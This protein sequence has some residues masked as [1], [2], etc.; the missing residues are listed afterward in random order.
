MPKV[1]D[2]KSVGLI[3]DIAGNFG[4]CVVAIERRNYPEAYALPAGHLDGDDFLACIIRE[5]NE[6]VGL[7]LLPTELARSFQG[8]IAN[9]CKRQG[10]SYHD[11]DV[12]R[13]RENAPM[14]VLKAGSDAKTAKL[15]S[16]DEL[17]VWAKRTE[18]FMKKYGCLWTE[19][20]ILTNKIFGHPAEKKTDPEWLA[21]M[22]L[23]PVWYFILRHL[24]FFA[25]DPP[26]INAPGN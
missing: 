24:R 20:G 9:P 7:N 11:W 1:C 26:V 15:V 3:Y 21:E 13:L 25:W 22:G 4:K 18:Y 6:E 8:T 16:W 10:G 12:W 19:V 14:P 5:A 17:F 2:N 23:E